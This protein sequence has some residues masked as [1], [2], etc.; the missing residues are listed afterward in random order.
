MKVS[1]CILTY[2][3]EEYI[4]QTLNAAVNQ[5][6]SP[7]EIIVSD[8]GSTDR[9]FEIIRQFAKKYKGPNQIVI[10]QNSPNL[11][12]REHYNKVLYELSHGDIVIL[13]DGDDVS[14]ENR[15][16]EYVK[17]FERFPEV[18]MV[19]SKSKE[20]DSNLD[21]INKDGE[22]DNTFSI[23]TLAD[24][25]ENQNWFIHSSDSRALRRNVIEAFEPLKYPKAEDMSFF[26]RALMVGSE[27]YIR[28]PFVMH[29]HHETNASHERWTQ[30]M[31]NLL[32]RQM[33]EDVECAVRS[34]LISGKMAEKV[35]KKFNYSLLY[36]TTY[37]PTAFKSFSSFFYSVLSRVLDV[38]LIMR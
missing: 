17:V 31:K 14:D 27:C 32:E 2:N 23:N 34:Q 15:V 38:R 8:D 11:G 19:S 1:Y 10:N 16:E 13:A 26:L 33:C 7:M 28:T 9:T 30:E 5:T 29:R 24:Y 18:V 37:G 22:W 35:K 20:T 4:E 36:L 6:Y 21:V 12:L 3:Q 25:V